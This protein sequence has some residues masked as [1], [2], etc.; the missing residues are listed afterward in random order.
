MIESQQ[1]IDIDTG[2]VS[3]KDI[4][5]YFSLLEGG[6]PE[7]KLECKEIRGVERQ[8]ERHDRSLALVMFMLYDEDSNG[9]LDKQVRKRERESDG[10]GQRMFSSS[11][12]RIRS[13]I[14]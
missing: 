8:R 14:K 4:I 6:T 10:G 12:K 2:R 7:Q 3:L 5:C 11:R 1:Q 13:S 9:K